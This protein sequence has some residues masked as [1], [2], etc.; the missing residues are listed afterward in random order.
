MQKEVM[1]IDPE[2][3]LEWDQRD[4]TANESYYSRP[5]GS[6]WPNQVRLKNTATGKY[7]RL[8]W[9]PFDEA[10]TWSSGGDSVW[11]RRG[12]YIAI[13]PTP[14]VAIASG[15]EMIFVPTLTMA[16]DTDIPAVPISTHI[17][18]SLIAKIT[19]LGETYQGI[20]KDIVLLDRLIGDL[21]FYYST[22]GGENMTFQPD[23]VKP[24][25]YAGSGGAYGRPAA[26]R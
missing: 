1:K 16:A 4:I 25:G 24:Y 10:E 18:I 20:E 3:F 8:K 5:T 6:W 2:A 26:D 17:A 19:A 23:I 7:E 22:N 14:G 12:N 11:S 15:I 13:F 21:P 9:K